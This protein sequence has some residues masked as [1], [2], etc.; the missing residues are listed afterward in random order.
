MH[1][2]AFASLEEAFDPATNADYA[3]RYLSG[4][5]RD[6]AGRNWNIAVGLYHSHTVT[7][8]AAYRDRV[9][10]V[11]E[12]VIRGVLEPVPLYVRAIRQGTLRVA[13]GTGRSTPINVHR[14]PSARPQP[15]PSACRIAQVLGSYLNG[16]A[17]SRCRQA[18]QSAPP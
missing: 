18:A 16:P 10:L 8:A 6:E 12:Q 11:G 7:L 17:S 1:P 14:Q 5:Y 15:R 2:R 13:L 9:A 4:L 3:A